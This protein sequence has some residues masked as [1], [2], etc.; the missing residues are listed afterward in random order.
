M[1]SKMFGDQIKFFLFIDFISKKKAFNEYIIDFI[2][3]IKFHNYLNY[4]NCF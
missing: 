2:I 1:L 4:I 3:F